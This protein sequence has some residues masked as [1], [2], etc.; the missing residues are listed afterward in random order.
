[1]PITPPAGGQRQYVEKPLKVYGEQ[2]L[3]GGPLPVGAVDA[4]EPIYPASGGPY[5]NTTTGVFP[6]HN[7]DWLLTNRYTGQPHSVITD[8]D[9]Q[10]RFGTGAP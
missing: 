3:T 4:I 10:D 2:Y 1:M 7:T 5:A 9:F 6:L 8:A